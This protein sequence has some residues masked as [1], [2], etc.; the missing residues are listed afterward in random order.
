[1]TLTVVQVF[2]LMAAGAFAGFAVVLFISSLAV[3]VIVDD[4]DSHMEDFLFLGSAVFLALFLMTMMP[5]LMRL[6][7]G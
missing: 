3:V 2:Q 4:P 5:V 7:S 6:W 1:M